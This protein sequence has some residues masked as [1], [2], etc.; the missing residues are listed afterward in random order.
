MTVYVC[1]E[2][3]VATFLAVFGHHVKQRVALFRWRRSGWTV[4]VYFNE[5]HQ[6]VLKLH[7][8]LLSRPEPIPP[9]CVEEPWCHFKVQFV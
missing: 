5:V 6:C 3:K 2:E 8:I 4:S 9:T 1:L 7:T